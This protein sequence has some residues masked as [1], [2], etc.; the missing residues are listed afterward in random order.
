MNYPGTEKILETARLEALSQQTEPATKTPATLH[1]KIAA[2]VEAATVKHPE[3]SV[4]VILD[5]ICIGV[6]IGQEEK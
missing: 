5:M 1:Q 4:L 3:I 6:E 2:A